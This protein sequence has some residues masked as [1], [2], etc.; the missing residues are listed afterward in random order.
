MKLRFFFILL[1]SSTI[2]I[3]T[4][5]T[6]EP[7][8]EKALLEVTVSNMSDQQLP[9]EIV[10]FTSTKTK[11]VYKGHTDENGKFSILVPVGDTYEI[12]YKNIY[13][14]VKYSNLTIPSDDKIY[15]VNVQLRYYP[16]KTVILEN[17]EFDFDKASIR[18]SS[19]K[20][21]NDLA[22]VMNIKKNMKIEIAG[23]TD[24]K[25]SEEYNK[26][27]SQERAESVR[28]YLIL[29]GINGSQ[30]TAKGYGSSEA[31][32]PNT[33]SDGSDNP[34]GRQRNRRIEVHILD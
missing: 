25:G 24:S 15:T 6:L 29:K 10:S 34:E 7:T 16:A 17:V 30:V 12:L 18:P 3:L 8:L 2:A 20:T 14:D 27:L 4:A 1:F 23:H 11:E 32:A 33:N 9:N 22:E 28:K 19:Y 13:K 26:K 31:I 5:Q 21:L